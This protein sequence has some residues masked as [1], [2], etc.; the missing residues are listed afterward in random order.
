[1]ETSSNPTK[2]IP[3]AAAAPED[4]EVFLYAAS[5]KIH[6]RSVSGLFA[7]WRWAWCS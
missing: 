5:K 1:V 2:V 6:P 4:S 3:I 7:R